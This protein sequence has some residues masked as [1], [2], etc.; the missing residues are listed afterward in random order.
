M[1]EDARLAR[2][3]ASAFPDYR[4]ID[5]GYKE[6]R[7]YDAYLIL[8]QLP[9][10]VV[11]AWIGYNPSLT[12]D[13]QEQAA[14]ECKRRVD[15]FTERGRNGPYPWQK[16]TSDNGYQAWIRHRSPVGKTIWG[17]AV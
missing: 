1:F 6:N 10:G 4:V 12:Q 2:W 14:L 7:Q 8:D 5:Q 17:A 13:E 9:K 3:W 15:S 11:K 16:R